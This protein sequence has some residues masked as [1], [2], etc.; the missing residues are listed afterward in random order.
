MIPESESDPRNQSWNQ[1]LVCWNRNHRFWKTLELESESESALVESELESKSL[2]PE[3]FT[4]LLN[5][6]K[7]LRSMK[8][9]M[10]QCQNQQPIN[11]LLPPMAGTSKLIWQNHHEKF[12]CIIIAT[13]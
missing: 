6:S 10:Q 8:C 5:M 9:A 12:F 4:T 2:V 11:C 1:S 7:H 13:S 3:T